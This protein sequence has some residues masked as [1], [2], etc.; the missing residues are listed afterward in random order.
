MVDAANELIKQ[1]KANGWHSLWDGHSVTNRRDFE[2]LDRAI[3]ESI[4]D[5]NLNDIKFKHLPK[6]L[7]NSNQKQA[8]RL[9]REGAELHH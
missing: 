1:W 4:R 3:Q 7:G 2:D 6:S 9:A 5:K 8:D